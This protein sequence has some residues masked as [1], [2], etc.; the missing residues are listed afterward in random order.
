MGRVLGALTAPLLGDKYECKSDREYERGKN[1]EHEHE[2][3]NGKPLLRILSAPGTS[4]DDS[5]FMTF[6]SL[7][8][9]SLD[10]QP[11]IPSIYLK[12]GKKKAEE[13]DEDEDEEGSDTYFYYRQYWRSLPTFRLAHLKSLPIPSNTARQ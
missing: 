2:M 8:A 13:E 1:W 5:S 9:N 11:Q 7:P 12:E 6:S 10:I 4:R 3:G